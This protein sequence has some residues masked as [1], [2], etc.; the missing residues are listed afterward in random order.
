MVAGTNITNKADKILNTSRTFTEIDNCK[1]FF[2]TSNDDVYKFIE[3]NESISLN[4]INPNKL[5]IK[6]NFEEDE[7]FLKFKD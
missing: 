7:I 2:N 6:N 1:V 5:D 3:I 4:Y